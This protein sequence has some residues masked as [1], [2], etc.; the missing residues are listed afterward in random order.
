MFNFLTGKRKPPFGGFCV[1][2]LLQLVVKA[3]TKT[4]GVNESENIEGSLLVAVEG[5]YADVVESDSV[6]FVSPV[7]CLWDNFV[8]GMG[9]S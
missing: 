5:E 8:S 2:D 7:Y 6:H 9:L 4:F 1:L 3:T